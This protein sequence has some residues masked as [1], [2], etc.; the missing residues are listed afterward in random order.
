MTV[1]IV[2]QRLVVQESSF[3]VYERN[4]QSSPF[5]LKMLPLISKNLLFPASCMSAT[6]SYV[7]LSLHRGSWGRAFLVRLWL[8]FWP[9]ERATK[10]LIS[11]R[12]P[13]VN[14]IKNK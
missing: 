14:E 11:S 10:I 13:Y 2:F 8:L 12:Y 1:Y 6:D 5:L 9:L 3:C 4:F 7:N